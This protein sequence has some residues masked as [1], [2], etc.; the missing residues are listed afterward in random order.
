MAHMDDWSFNVFDLAEVT[1]QRS[2]SVMGF[3]LLQRSGIVARLQLDERKL[4]RWGWGRR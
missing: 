4:A 1:G 3:A 2:L